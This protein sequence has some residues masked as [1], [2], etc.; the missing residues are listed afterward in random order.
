MKKIIN[1]ISNLDVAS[2]EYSLNST[3]QRI[4][5]RLF[6]NDVLLKKFYEE[7]FGEFLIYEYDQSA[8]YEYSQV[9]QQ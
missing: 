4:V 5:D 7:V 3:V 1:N 9:R 8:T 6:E 2:N